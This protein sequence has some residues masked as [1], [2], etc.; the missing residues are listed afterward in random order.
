MEE[1]KI[2]CVVLDDEQHAI[3]VLVSHIQETP[4]L[5]LVCAT[6][7]H[8]EAARMINTAAVDL[9][10]LDIQMPRVTGLDFIQLIRDRCYIIFC[11]AYAQYA[12]DGFEHDVVD[13]LLKPVGYGR[14]LKAVG[15]ALQLVQEANALVI[16]EKDTQDYM[17]VKNGVKGKS[18]KISF[19]ELM[20]VEAQKNYVLFHQHSGKIITYMSIT[21]TVTKLP[22]KQFMR[23]HRSF[24][25]RLDQITAVEGNIVRLKNTE[26]TV[27]I[28]EIYKQELFK[29]L[30][31]D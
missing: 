19:G 2:N 13:F 5:H 15:K 26:I 11:S 7:S 8:Q 17:F 28:G 31:I 23:I 9:V 30:G 25:V 10:F 1:L 3:D 29:V 14:F 22:S 21:D 12:V 16:T 20:Y 18:L 6:S 24:I 27:P 4:M